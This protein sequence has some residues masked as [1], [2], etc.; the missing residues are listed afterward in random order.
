MSRRRLW[1]RWVWRQPGRA[2]APP[3]SARGRLR[4]D[5]DAHFL[6]EVCRQGWALVGDA[7]CHK[8]PIMAVG[9]C[10]A[11]PA[12]ELPAHARLAALAN[13]Q[14]PRPRYG[15][16]L[17]A[18]PP[19]RL[20]APHSVDV[21][22]LARAYGTSRPTSPSTS[23]PEQGR[24][25]TTAFHQQNPSGLLSALRAAAWRERAPTTHRSPRC[26]AQHLVTGLAG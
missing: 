11:P 20:A 16:G 22:R 8:D 9:V 4:H 17:P 7:A 6:K 1:P 23:W 3:V 10:D 14:R 2:R 5:R 24:M 19:H 26:L 25:Q 15:A 12:A 13:Y 21:V 18:K